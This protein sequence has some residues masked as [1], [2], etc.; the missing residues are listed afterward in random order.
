VTDRF[1]YLGAPVGDLLGRRSLLPFADLA[2]VPWIGVCRLDAGRTVAEPIPPGTTLEALEPGLV[3]NLCARPAA[4]RTLRTHGIDDTPTM[5]ALEGDPLAAERVLD[6]AFLR[7]GQKLLHASHMAVAIPRRGLILAR[8]AKI[9]DWDHWEAFTSWVDELYRTATEAD[10]LTRRVFSVRKGELTGVIFAEP[11]EGHPRREITQVDDEPWVSRTTVLDDTTGRTALHLVVGV[12]S[13]ADLRRTVGAAFARYAPEMRDEDDFG[14]EI[15]F[16]VLDDRL[17]RSGD[18]LRAVAE[19]QV[20]LN[21]AARALASDV[22][23]RVVMQYG[24]H[25]PGTRVSTPK[26]TA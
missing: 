10:R 14:G 19:L 17:P 6:Y 15:R 8:N 18:V 25:P 22:P 23:L 3:A 21:E 5:I 16:V 2:G 12:T 20:S 1:P 7:A 24:G 11:P 26:P 9:D 13:V 4:W